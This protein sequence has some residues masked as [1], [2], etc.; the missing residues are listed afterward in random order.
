MQQAEANA[1]RVQA[2]VAK[3]RADTARYTAL[4]D[5]N[6]ISEEKVNDIRTNEAA[7]SAN[8]LASKAAVELVRLQLSYATIRAPFDGVVGARLVFPS[9]SVKINDTTLAVVN[10]ARPCSSVSRSPK[11]TCHDCAP[12]WP[13]LQAKVAA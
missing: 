9:S 4:K 7:A 8:L 12:P 6:F 2:L 13:P 11:N 3:T 5:R 1:T 10:R